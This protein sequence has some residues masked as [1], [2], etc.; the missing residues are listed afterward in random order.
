MWWQ[1]RR[2][3]RAATAPHSDESVLSR[4]AEA[5]LS[6]QLVQTWH[7][8]WVMVPAWGWMTVLAHGGMGEIAALGD[9]GTYWSPSERVWGPAMSFLAGE[10]L[11][12]A[13][14]LEGLQDLQRT[15][16]VPLELE[17]LRTEGGTTV[18]PSELV[19]RVLTAVADFHPSTA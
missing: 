2:D 7:D 18:E 1:R 17:M 11:S 19:R 16:L 14:T 4:E 5:F 9:A 15:A 10:V 13:G 8:Q 3:D 6:G 12:R